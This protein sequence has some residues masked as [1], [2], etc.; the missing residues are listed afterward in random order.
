MKFRVLAIAFGFAIAKAYA[1]KY[2]FAHVVVGDTSAH[3]QGTW[4]Q[5]ILLAAEVGIDA[6]ALNM[7][8][9]DPNIP[10]QV[11]N[12]FNALDA[13]NLD[14]KLFFSFDYLGGGEPWP[15]TGNNSVVSYLQEYATSQHYGNLYFQYDDLPFVSTF[16]G[17]ANINDWAPGGIIRS[18]VNAFF[19][20]D[21]TSLGPGGLSPYLDNIEGFFS[22]NIW[23]EGATDM[24]TT[25][26]VQ[27]QQAIGN[28]PYMMGV[29]PWF[30][31]SAS[32]GV[33][34]V[35]R[36][37][38]LW[39]ERWLETL[40]VN[41]QFVEIVTWNDFGEAHYIGPI[42]SSSE[43][44]TGS[45]VYV[46][47]MPHDGWRAL[48]PYYIALYKGNFYDVFIDQMQYWYRLA[49]A[50]GGS[51]CGVEGNAQWQTEMSPNNIVQDEVFFTALLSSE[52]TVTVQIGNNAAVS[53]Y[54]TQGLN[55][56]SQA[57][58]GQTGNVTFSIVRNGKAVKTGT[59]PAITANTILS[60]G[61]SN[62][63]AWVGSM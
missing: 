31:H 26:D 43:I 4:E 13:L 2:V 14:F 3:T 45:G 28:K 25:P 59:G 24:T 19:V 44:P 60:D 46:E 20:P 57:F 17:T 42:H 41:P 21:W 15:A 36:G 52:A 56:W 22:W 35:W 54:G 62:Y 18:E 32:G 47:G 50:A 58:N 33:D 7:G 39:H 6:F 23:P 11:T 49:P 30:F 8:Y 37:D 40:Q 1:S 61:C 5:D 51:T 34:W 55:H 16:E 38:D 27:F 29:S 48:L 10:I 63:N 53:Y 9:P 12:A